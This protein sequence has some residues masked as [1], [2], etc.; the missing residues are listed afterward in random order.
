MTLRSL[1]AY[2][3]RWLTYPLIVFLLSACIQYK[4]VES[5]NNRRVAQYTVKLTDTLYSIA[6]RYGLDYRQLAQ[7][8]G[9]ETNSI[10][11]PGQTLFLSKPADTP[12]VSTKTVKQ[13]TPQTAAQSVS[14]VPEPKVRTTIVNDL[15]KGQW[16]WPTKGRLLSTFS[17]TQLH[18]K[19]IDIAGKKGQP[20]L[21]V[22]SGKV[23]YSG[24]GLAGYGNLIIV[25]HS[26]TY[27]SAYAY[28]HNRL[29]KEGD[30]IKAGTT[31]AQMG[32][33][34]NG[35]A[36]LHFQ[37]RKNGKPVD[38]MGFLVKP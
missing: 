32:R 7:W 11:V 30:L 22:A 38:P 21:A 28:C 6:W 4:S 34:K 9:I 31:I 13:S 5:P 18:R 2:P 15:P 24:N 17:A 36:K 19:G 3:L 29:V 35:K 33:D 26:D 23:V 12:V 25:K 14:K 16:L 20:V 27:L 8:N 37:V 1:V 10:I